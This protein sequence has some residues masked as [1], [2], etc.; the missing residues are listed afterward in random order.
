M[1]ASKR[2]DFS[3]ATRVFG[4]SGC[5]AAVLNGERKRQRQLAVMQ[6]GQAD[7]ASN[8]LSSQAFAG[9]GRQRAVGAAR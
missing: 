1:G 8:G 5:A 3:R 2:L 4:G 9:R 7:G 6:A